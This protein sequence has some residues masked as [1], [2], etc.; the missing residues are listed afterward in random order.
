MEEAREAEAKGAVEAGQEAV[1]APE[2]AVETTEAGAAGVEGR[3]E[4]EN[5][6]LS[7][8]GI[9]ASRAGAK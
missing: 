1:E 7:A 6:L 3:A 2:V 5:L 4:E 8:V 9:A